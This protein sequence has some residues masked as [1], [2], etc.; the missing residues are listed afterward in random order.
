[1][2]RLIL[3]LTALFALA[4]FRASAQEDGY[5]VFIPISKYI[6]LGDAV[7]L[8]A[9]FADNLEIS[10]LSSSGDSSK[11]QAREILKSFFDTYTPRSFQI[12]HKAARSNMKYVLGVLNAGGEAFLVT[13]FVNFKDNAYQIQQF[14]IERQT[15]VF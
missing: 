8:S 13:I 7:K 10:V 3:L 2:K 1:M 14:K 12:T 9:W 6:A 15:A 4:P 5:E 11:T